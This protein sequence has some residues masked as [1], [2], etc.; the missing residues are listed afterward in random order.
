MLG[1]GAAIDPFWFIYQQHNQPEVL[2]LL[3]KYR[4]GNL[5]EEDKQGTADLG[6]PVS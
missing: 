4:I 6:D 5:R 1:A 2:A 3:E